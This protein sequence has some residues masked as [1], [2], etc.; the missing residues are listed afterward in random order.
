MLE[1]LAPGG[2]EVLPVRNSLGPEAVEMEIV[3]N[4]DIF[5]HFKETGLLPSLGSNG[6]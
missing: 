4:F 5:Q 6:S 3:W 1:S 2:I